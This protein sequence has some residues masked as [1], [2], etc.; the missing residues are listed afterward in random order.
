M[1]LRSAV[2]GALLV[3][4][5]LGWLACGGDDGPRCR[6]L[7]LGFQPAAGLEGCSVVDGAARVTLGD[8]TGEGLG[9]AP[10]G[11]AAFDVDVPEHGELSFVLAA[12]LERPATFRVELDDYGILE[13][14]VPA[15]ARER[16]VLELPGSGRARLSFSLGID[17]AGSDRPGGA[18]FEP[19]VGPK[20]APATSDPRP[21]VVLFLADTLR[22]DVLERYGGAA[23]LAPNLNALAAKSLAFECRSSATWTLPAISSLLSGHAPPQHGA[24]A[25]DRALGADV[26]T[27]AEEFARAGYRTAAITDSFFVSRRHGLDQGFQW[28]EE[29]PQD[30]WDLSATLARATELV[31]RDDGRPLFLFVHT[32]RAHKP[33]RVGLEEDPAPFEA[34]W[35]AT[36]ARAGAT[37]GPERTAFYRSEADTYRSLYERGVAG[38]DAEF[39]PWFAA[40][41]AHGLFER[42]LFVFTSDHGEAFGE[43]AEMWHRGHTWDTQIRVPLFLYSKAL[44]ARAGTAP[45]LAAHLDLARTLTTWCGVDP[46]S[47]WGGE[48]LLAAQGPGRAFAFRLE[49]ETDGKRAGEAALF[50]GRRKVYARFEVGGAA[51]ELAGAF[52]VGVDPREEEQDQFRTDAAWPR[53]VFAKLRPELEALLQA[54]SQGEEVELDEAARKQLEG[55][56]YTGDEDH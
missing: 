30:R 45:T 10:G 49:T 36:A 18:I 56:G 28:F 5:L 24:V 8:V 43:H 38:L 32:Y 54:R 39:G 4:C 34:A 17:G 1:R 52:D 14:K 2:L 9:L 50:D 53:E 27:L 19:V 20:P 7:A 46:A 44:A 51:P 3:P 6:R 16:H 15:G 41:D 47:D 22:A 42:G 33:Y 25:P 55:L 26:I 13:C 23:E 31:A 12:G 21:D 11:S 48:N 35:A 37:K 40:L 29:I